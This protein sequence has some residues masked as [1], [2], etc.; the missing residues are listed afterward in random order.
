MQNNTHV[1]KLLATNNEPN[2]SLSYIISVG[3]AKPRIM[4]KEEIQEHSK[5]MSLLK[6]FFKVV[7]LLTLLYFFVCSIKFIEDGFK[8]LT[9]KNGGNNA[10]PLIPYFG[11]QYQLNYIS[12]LCNILTISCGQLCA[13]LCN[14]NQERMKSTNHISIG[15]KLHHLFWH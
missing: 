8:L 14:L 15:L 6:A 4:A 10:M 7:A 2:I 1:T 12:K 3:N 5:F 11:T 9:G 13:L